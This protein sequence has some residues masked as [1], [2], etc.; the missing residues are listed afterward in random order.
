[1]VEAAN[2]WAKTLAVMEDMLWEDCCVVVGMI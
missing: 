1:M 2:L